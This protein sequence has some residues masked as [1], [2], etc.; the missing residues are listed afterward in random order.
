[1]KFYST[2]TQFYLPSGNS[3]GG[4]EVPRDYENLTEAL[5][6]RKK[7][8]TNYK[9]SIDP[10]KP[11]IIKFGNWTTYRWIGYQNPKKDTERNTKDEVT[12]S[13]DHTQ[14]I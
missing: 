6:G 8:I 3:C 14:E 4:K 11:E 1:M 12:L 7:W 2:C 5:K 13:Y 10:E 9:T